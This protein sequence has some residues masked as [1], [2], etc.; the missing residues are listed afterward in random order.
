MTDDRLTAEELT[1]LVKRVFEPRPEDRALAIIVDMPDDEVPDTERWRERR[2]LAAGW[3]KELL[4]ARSDHGLEISLFLYPNVHSNNADLPASAW[5]WIDDTVPDHI[6]DMAGQ[7]EEP[8][9]QVLSN[10]Q[11]VMA[12]TQFSTTAPSK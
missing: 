5:R 2:A 7:L 6:E 12:P 8:M 11:L 10:H 4:G 3:V 1:N 9:E